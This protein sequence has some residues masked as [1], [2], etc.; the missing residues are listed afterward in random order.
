[1]LPQYLPSFIFNASYVALLAVSPMDYVVT[2]SSVVSSYDCADHH[3][4]GSH[5]SLM[6]CV[7]T[8][9]LI[10]SL[11]WHA[12]LIDDL[13]TFCWIIQ[14]M[15]LG[16][17]QKY[18][19]DLLITADCIFLFWPRHR[20]IEDKSDPDRNSIKTCSEMALCSRKAAN[21]LSG[22][23]D[24]NHHQQSVWQERC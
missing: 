22:R 18:C 7:R 20:F 11:G 24:R 2:E 9:L 14:I 13:L 6:F 1:M 16:S 10:I 3:R 17:F 12:N 21:C 19:F 23:S 15:L 5:A 4:S 8:F